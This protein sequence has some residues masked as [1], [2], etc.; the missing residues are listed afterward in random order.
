MPQL[1][2]TIDHIACTK[3]RSVLMLSF[4]DRALK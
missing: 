4:Y 2:H 3:Q 1:F